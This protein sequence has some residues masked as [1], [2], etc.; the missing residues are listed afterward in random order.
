MMK[1]EPIDPQ[2]FVENRRKLALHMAPKSLAVLNANDIPI[3]SA[4]G[5]RSFVQQT[6][7]FYLSGIDQE[8]SILLL[9]PDA[10]N[11]QHREILF[12]KE[13]D[14]FIAVWEG[15]K[16]TK[17]RATEVSG[18]KTVYWLQEF[19]RV[20]N[21]LMVQAQCVYLNTNEHLRH[22]SPV[23]TRDRRFVRW[24]MEQYPLHR[25]ERLQPILH[26]L[27]G[28][29]STIEI[30]LIAKACSI[31]EKA[32][33]RILSFVKPGVWEYEIEAEMMHEFIRNRSRR[34]AYEPIIASGANSCV[35]HYIENSRQCQEG[36]LLL[37]DIGAEYANYA[38]DL[39]RTIPVSGRFTTRQKQVYNAVLHV[40]KEAISMLTPGVS[41]KEYTKEVGKI[42]ESE[43]ISIGLLDKTDVKNQDPENPLFRKYFMHGVSH[44]LGLDVHDYGDFYRPIEPGMVFTVE[45]GVY[46]REESIGIRIEND[47]VI[48]E[49]K[50][51][52]LMASIPREVEEIE[53][54]MNA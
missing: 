2:L 47:V 12:L 31:T 17:A 41:I 52:D 54:L 32:F 5:T 35:L 1:Y 43:L 15:E 19:D 6:D 42:M 36:D 27:R 10:P 26:T 24:C 11:E 16:L 9:F 22:S 4:D 25:Y 23:E 46:I 8:E 28:V 39:S 29:K 38:S 21:E 34:P 48:T 45:P 30:E 7:L 40:Q 51:H 44:H 13:T 37:M 3:T 33:R 53:T 14:E 18:T 50:P 49:G 20:F